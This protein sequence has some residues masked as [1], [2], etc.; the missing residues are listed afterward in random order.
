MKNV[1]IGEKNDICLF[2]DH[3]FC[4]HLQVLLQSCIELNP[5]IFCLAI[6]RTEW[7]C[8][9]KS[10]DIKISSFFFLVIFEY[11]KVFCISNYENDLYQLVKSV[12]KIYF[13][14]Y[15]LY[16]ISYKKSSIKSFILR[17][18]TANLWSLGLRTF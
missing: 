4:K 9:Q 14:T 10:N 12:S 17:C 5:A 2:C 11:K 8:F 18:Y 16:C 1:K 13:Y 15:I 6:I 7:Y 3:D